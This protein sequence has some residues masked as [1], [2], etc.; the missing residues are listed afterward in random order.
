MTKNVQEIR[1]AF[2]LKDTVVVTKTL[3][4]MQTKSGDCRMVQVLCGR[5]GAYL[6]NDLKNSDRRN[7]V[8]KD[9]KRGFLTQ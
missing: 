5:C 2:S 9:E 4:D 3:F 7:I 6:K 1:P 8:N